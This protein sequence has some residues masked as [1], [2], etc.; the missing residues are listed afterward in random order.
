MH[1]EQFSSR[2]P[3]AQNLGLLVLAGRFGPSAGADGGSIE[4][5]VE[6]RAGRGIALIRVR[7]GRVSR[8]KARDGVYLSA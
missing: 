6:L 7:R 8:V 1:F 5:A 3:H 2:L 4:C